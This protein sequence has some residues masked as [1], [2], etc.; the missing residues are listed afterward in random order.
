[1]EEEEALRVRVVFDD[2]KLLTKPQRSEGLKRCWLLLRRPS[3]STISDLASYILTSFNL[4]LSCPHGLLLSMDDFVLPPFESTSIL[5]DKD[6]IRVRKKDAIVIDVIELGDYSCQMQCSGVLEKQNTVSSDKLLPI[7][8][9]GEDSGCETKNDKELCT[10]NENAIH[11]GTKSKR[12]I[13]HPD[14]IEGSKY[15]CPQFDFRR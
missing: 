5:K 12:K 11:T 8:E 3:I 9:F 13:K 7:R 4:K 2:R 14:G 15:S 1:M 6:I 10:H